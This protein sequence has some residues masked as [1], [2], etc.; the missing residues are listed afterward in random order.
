[1]GGPGSGEWPRIG[2]KI[3]VEDCRRLSVRTLVAEGWLAN[4]R[5]GTITW[6]HPVTGWRLAVVELTVRTGEKGGWLL[7]LRSDVSARH[8][9]VQQVHVVACPGPHGRSRW[10]FLCPLESWGSPGRRVQSL[11]DRGSLF[12]CRHCHD[13]AYRSSQEAHREERRRRRG[14][15]YA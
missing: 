15:L 9:A 1:M 8:S 4:G 12:G 11:Y 6:Q 10:C 13:L 3:C 7:E 5:T 2:A 14:L